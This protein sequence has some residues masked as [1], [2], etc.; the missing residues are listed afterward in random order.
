MTP[1]AATIPVQV[2]SEANQREHH[3]AKHRR[4]KRQREVAAA[5][6]YQAGFNSMDRV[7]AA[8]TLTRVY[9]G[10]C[11]SMDDDNLAGSFKHVQDAVSAVIGID[12]ARIKWQYRQEPGDD[13]AVVVE[14]TE[15][16]T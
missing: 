6:L 1:R 16:A 8:V 4:K 15:F 9:A 13:H 5:F 14:I 10:R 12:D 7:V 11:K 3:M 2:V